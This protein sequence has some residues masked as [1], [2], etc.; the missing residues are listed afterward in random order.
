M[1]TSFGLNFGFLLSTIPAWVSWKNTIYPLSTNCLCD[2]KFCDKLGTIRAFSSI[3]WCKYSL[4][5]FTIRWSNPECDALSWSGPA[6]WIT[7]DDGN[8]GCTKL[9]SSLQYASVP[10][11]SGNKVISDFVCSN[12]LCGCWHC[13]SQF[14]LCITSVCALHFVSVVGNILMYLHH[15]CWRTYEQYWNN[16]PDKYDCKDHRAHVA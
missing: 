16:P 15:P 13:H 7:V 9:S 2:V 14:C 5:S 11:S 10:V 1:T 6:V 8:N 12:Y 4:S 3:N